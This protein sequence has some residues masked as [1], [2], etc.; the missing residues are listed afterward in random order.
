MVTLRDVLPELA[1]RYEVEI[2]AVSGAAAERLKEAEGM[3]AWLRQPK[4][5]SAKGRR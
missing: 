2:E 5:I 1:Q 4:S 3:G